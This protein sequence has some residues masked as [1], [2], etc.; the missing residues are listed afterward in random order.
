MI[1]D[2]IL[3]RYENEQNGF[4]SFDAEQ[5]CE[6]LSEYDI[7]FLSQPFNMLVDDSRTQREYKEYEAKKALCQYI[8]GCEYNIGI[9]AYITSRVWTVDSDEEM[10]LIDIRPNF[11]TVYGF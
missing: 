7:A 1:I 4:F 5:F 2:L 11:G 3:E 6:E 10:P 9:L 8:M